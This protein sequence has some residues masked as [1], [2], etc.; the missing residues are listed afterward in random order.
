MGDLGAVSEGARTHI[1]IGATCEAYKMS[2][3]Q[4]TCSRCHTS[5][6]LDEREYNRWISS[7]THHTLIICCCWSHW[8]YAGEEV[9][10][11]KDFP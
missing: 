3:G 7:A 4:R 5:A 11:M 1:D 2:A 6:I 9:A 10:M 8:M